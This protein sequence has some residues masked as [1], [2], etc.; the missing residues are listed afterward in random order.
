MA[1]KIKFGDIVIQKPGWY[2]P[3]SDCSKCG[4]RNCYTMEEDHRCYTCNHLIFD[5]EAFL[6][7]SQRLRQQSDEKA[8]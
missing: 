8:D 1:I 7:I 5:R 2:G 3:S 6:N 4:Q